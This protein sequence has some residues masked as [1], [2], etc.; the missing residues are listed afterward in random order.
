MELIG[1]IKNR[2]IFYISTDASLKWLNLL[3]TEKWGVY[4]IADE[5]SKEIV[6]KSI[7]GILDN[8]VRYIC[9]T[10]EL[11]D[12]T[13]DYF[14]EEIGWRGVQYE[15]KMRNKYDYEQSP[16]TTMH[17]N[18]EEGFWFASVLACYD[19]KEIEKVICIDF[20]SR[21]VKNCLIELV[22]K[23]NKGWLPII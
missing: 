11:G 8:N 12:L 16:I 19:E 10:G 14:Y 20:T 9:C 22:K 6:Y 1:K 3:P 23:I 15:E 21:K 18:F 7:T 4:T 2:E 13:E 17:R 5:D